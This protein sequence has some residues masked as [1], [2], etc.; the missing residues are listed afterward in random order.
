MQILI[1]KINII[2][3]DKKIILYLQPQNKNGEVAQLVRA[4]RFLIGKVPD[5]GKKVEKIMAR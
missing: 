3:I 2:L 5:S 1:R 4:S